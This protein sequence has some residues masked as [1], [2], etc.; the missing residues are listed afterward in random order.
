MHSGKYN[1]NL[2]RNKNANP[3]LIDD[4]SMKSTI[5][6]TIVTSNYYESQN[7]KNTENKPTT[8]CY[9]KPTLSTILPTKPNV[10]TAMPSQVNISTAVPTKLIA[11]TAMPSQV[12]V[13]TA[14]PTK[15][16]T[17]TAVRTEIKRTL[18]P[19]LIPTSLSNPNANNV[20]LIKFELPKVKIVREND[21]I[22]RRIVENTTI[23]K[24]S[25]MIENPVYTNVTS[26][27]CQQIRPSTSSFSATMPNTDTSSTGPYHCQL[28]KTGTHPRVS[29]S[30]VNNDEKV[31]NPNQN[32]LVITVYPQNYSMS[33]VMVPLSKSIP[34]KIV[35]G[36]VLMQTGQSLL[37][38]STANTTVCNL[39]SQITSSQIRPS[40][41]ISSSNPSF[42][43]VGKLVSVLPKTVHKQTATVSTESVL[44]K[45]R[46][47]L[48]KNLEILKKTGGK[49]EVFN[50]TNQTDNTKVVRSQKQML[51]TA[52]QPTKGVEKAIS[53][54][55]TSNPPT[56]NDHLAA[57]IKEVIVRPPIIVK[58]INTEFN[59]SSVSIL[60]KAGGLH[61]QSTTLKKNNFCFAIE[62]IYRK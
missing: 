6:G 29:F 15:L 31:T 37:A 34:A 22:N 12:N 38:Y 57:P 54:C 51:P 62:N 53:P 55:F 36:K 44:E 16:N 1:N 8:A 30:D 17:S 52:N 39:T 25:S 41:I 50:Q 23:C 18:R 9:T 56:T 14:V 45:T 26:S 35:Q 42:Q 27:N 40:N 46:E 28:V 48:Q 4:N 43:N 7:V 24:Q 61:Q 32:P 5:A 58:V 59:N 19:M 2:L 3:E 13:S 20:Q 60:P 47:V 33:S 10:V 49:T 21:V 11:A